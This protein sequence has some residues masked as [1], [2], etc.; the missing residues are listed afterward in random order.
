MLGTQL[1]L[2]GIKP[3]DGGNLRV[4]LV[5][6]ETNTVVSFTTTEGAEEALRVE[7]RVFTLTIE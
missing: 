7:D 6:E 3:I 4:T 2:G 1:K 5:D